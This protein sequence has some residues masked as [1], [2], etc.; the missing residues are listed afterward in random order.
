MPKGVYAGRGACLVGYAP[1]NITPHYPPYGT[2]VEIG[3]D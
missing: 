3:G 2:Q 1:I